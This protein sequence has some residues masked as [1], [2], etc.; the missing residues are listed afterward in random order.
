MVKHRIAAAA[1]TFAVAA[2]AAA[3]APS[4]RDE[5]FWIG[6]INKASTVINT[7]EGLL[8]AG[9]APRIAAGLDTML[10]AADKPGARRPTLV[11]TF[12]PLL[13]EAAGV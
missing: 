8:D 13:I 4:K 5:F 12:E 10:K 9:L 7:E 2:P 3:Q 6:E 1:L 11:I